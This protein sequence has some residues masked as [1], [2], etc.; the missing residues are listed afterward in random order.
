MD[1]VIGIEVNQQA[2]DDAVYNAQ[3]NG[4]FTKK[5]PPLSTPIPG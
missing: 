4:K 5:F 1:K 3:A 2:I